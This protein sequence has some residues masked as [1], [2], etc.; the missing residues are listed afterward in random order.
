M[1]LG[2]H[3][4]EVTQ[5]CLTL[6]NPMDCSPPGSSIH[7]IFQAR[8]LE[9][10]AISFSRG[11]SWPGIEPASP[12]SAGTFFTTEPSRKPHIYIYILFHFFSLWFITGCWIWFPVPYSRPLLFIRLVGSSL[13]LLIPNPHS[14]PPPCPL[15][16]QPQVWS[17]S[18]SP[19]HRQVHLCHVLDSTR[20]SCICL[21]VS[22]FT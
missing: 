19:L 8:L 18:V 12:A 16:W 15:S 1:D 20:I 6:C 21:S 22:D 3:G 5:S 13:Y 14:V 10:V 7:G 9:C 11:A 2:W 17:F 4:N